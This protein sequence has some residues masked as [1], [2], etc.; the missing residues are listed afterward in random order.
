MQGKYKHIILQK[1]NSKKSA[2]PQLSSAINSSIIMLIL[3]FKEKYKVS[4]LLYV[5]NFFYCCKLSQ[6]MNS[7]QGGDRITLVSCSALLQQKANERKE[8]NGLAAQVKGSGEFTGQLISNLTL[9]YI[10]IKK[11]PTQ[12]RTTPVPQCKCMFGNNTQILHC[13]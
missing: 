2:I 13:L 9:C 6:L 8:R 4:D 10:S 12:N 7:L 3:M 1:R 11:T 5:S